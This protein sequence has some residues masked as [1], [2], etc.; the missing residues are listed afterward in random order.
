MG[1][2]FFVEA[3]SCYLVEIFLTEHKLEIYTFSLAQTR[4]MIRNYNVH[5][6]LENIGDQTKNN[7]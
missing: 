5:F 4:H 7:T 2:S 3:L 1:S 6:K